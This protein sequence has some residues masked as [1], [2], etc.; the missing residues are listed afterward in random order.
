MLFKFELWDFESSDRALERQVS[1]VDQR[2]VE[3]QNDDLLRRSLLKNF[4]WIAACIADDFKLSN[5]SLSIWVE[6]RQLVRLH[7]QQSHGQKLQTNSLM[8]SFMTSSMTILMI[9]LWWRR[10]ADDRQPLLNRLAAR[11]SFIRGNLVRQIIFPHFNKRLVNLGNFCKSLAV[12]KRFVRVCAGHLVLPWEV[13]GG[14][15]FSKRL[16]RNR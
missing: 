12:Y 8:I 1:I 5:A 16:L 2:Q 9:N 7:D 15:L 14:I 11:S 3:I 4:V 6:L 10:A 13:L